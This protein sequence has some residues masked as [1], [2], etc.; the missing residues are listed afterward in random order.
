MK[1]P[2]CNYLGF[3]TGERC[4]NC[5]Y[6]FSL[7]TMTAEPAGEVRLHLSMESPSDP[8]AAMPLDTIVAA[9]PA[10]ASAAAAATTPQPGALRAVPSLPLFHPA[11]DDRPLVTLPTAP[12]PP[13][14][15]R[16]TPDRPRRSSPKPVR[17]EPAVAAPLRPLDP[18]LRFA[19]DVA[20]PVHESPSAARARGETAVASGAARRLAAALI[21]HALLLAVD[22]TVFYFTLKMAGL[23]LADW[24]L[25]P[26]VPLAAFLGLLKLAYFSA[27]TIV[28]GQTIGK[29]AVRIRV[30]GDDGSALDPSRAIQ[31]TLV[32]AVSL[33]VAG[34]GLVPI[35][36]SSDRRGLHDRLARTRV[37]R[38]LV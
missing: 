19:E 4:R 15:V 26:P 33:L 2:K 8:L 5:G 27:F 32:G 22:G 34:A 31:R 30:V 24:Q 12:R 23:T 1:C 35:V 14:A 10:P 17:R 6:D 29:M 18:P 20:A 13:L 7:S 11:D 21:D 28:G 36:V 38:E 3:D 16:R 9:P 37:V 25:L